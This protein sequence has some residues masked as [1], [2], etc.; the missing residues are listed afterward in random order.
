MRSHLEYAH[1]FQYEV[2][3][4]FFSASISV[5]LMIATYDNSH[6]YVVYNVIQRFIELSKYRLTFNSYLFLDVAV[7]REV[8]AANTHQQSQPIIVSLYYLMDVY[9]YAPCP[10]AVQLR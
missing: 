5:F 1:F 6:E 2:L 4:Q 8:T 10:T 7:G 3:E 9:G